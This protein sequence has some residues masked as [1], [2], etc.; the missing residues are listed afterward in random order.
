MNIFEKF[1]QEAKEKFLSFVSERIQ[2][3]RKLGIE[4]S[5][6]EYESLFP[7]N[8]YER[9]HLFPLLTKEALIKEAKYALENCRWGGNVGFHEYY[10]H[11]HSYDA[12]LLQIAVPELIKKLENKND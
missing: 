6:E 7:M 10:L 3:R 4:L 11:D 5:I 2:E 1:A 12:W 9:H 8:S